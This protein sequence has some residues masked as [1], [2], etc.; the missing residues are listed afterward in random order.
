MHNIIIYV[1]IL[2]SNKINQNI[3]ILK[4]N[5]STMKKKRM[6]E[7]VTRTRYGDMGVER[8]FQLFAFWGWRGRNLDGIAEVTKSR[9][10]R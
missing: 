6:W 1:L 7:Y 8:Q 4:M 5:K 10:G 9:R 2:F 3:L